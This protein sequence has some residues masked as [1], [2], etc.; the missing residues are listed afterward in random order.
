MFSEASAL[1]HIGEWI[2]KMFFPTLNADLPQLDFFFGR[3]IHNKCPFLFVTLKQNK[4]PV[5]IKEI[6]VKNLLIQPVQYD[7]K[8]ISLMPTAGPSEDGWKS[9]APCMINVP[10]EGSPLDRSPLNR[11]EGFACEVFWVKAAESFKGE[12]TVTAVTTERFKTIRFT[13]L[14]ARNS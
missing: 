12:V 3:D 5:S 13:K 7:R 14:L 8:W 11:K 10:S 1:I 9:S 6:R 4:L 2:K